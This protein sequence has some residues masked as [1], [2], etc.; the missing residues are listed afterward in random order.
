MVCFQNLQHPVSQCSSNVV[1]LAD[2]LYVSQ[3]T[4]LP[5]Q[6]FCTQVLLS[7]L[8]SCTQVLLCQHSLF[9]HL[10]QVEHLL[11]FSQQKHMQE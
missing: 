6:H 10:R 2:E 9:L 3:D 5:H 1:D 4:S 8:H 7:Q 11:L